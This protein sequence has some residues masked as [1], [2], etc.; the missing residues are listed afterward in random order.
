VVLDTARVSIPRQIMSNSA[1]T[2]AIAALF[3]IAG[4]GHFVMPA[5][6][7]R[8]VPTWVPNARMATYLSG[9]AEIAGAIGVLYA[10][11]RR[12][13]GIGLIALL[14]AVYPANINM[15]QMA[16]ASAASSTMYLA[17]LWMRLPLQ[18][19]MV[20]WVYGAAVRR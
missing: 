1:S 17:I 6:F 8:I 15:L 14:V 7:D 18:P 16:R 9:V 2:F 13:A 4:V 19:L 5:W 3:L 11:T 10:P 12:A 20:W